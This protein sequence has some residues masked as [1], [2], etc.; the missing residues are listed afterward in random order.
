MPTGPYLQVTDITKEATIMQVREFK[1]SALFDYWGDC[2]E[3]LME[4]G[5]KR[6][7]FQDIY[8]QR[9]LFHIE[10][11]EMKDSVAAFGAY[12]V[13]ARAAGYKDSFYDYSFANDREALSAKGNWYLRI[14][15][16]KRD[17]V[18]GL[19]ILVNMSKL[20]LSKIPARPYVAPAILT[21]GSLRQFRS[22]LKLIRGYLGLYYGFP[23]WVNIFSGVKFREIAV[24]PLSQPGSWLNYARVAFAD[25][26]ELEKFQKKNDF[27]DPSNPGFRKRM[28]GQTYWAFL[29]IGENIALL[30]QSEGNDPFL[31]P[32]VEQIEMIGAKK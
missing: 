20:I 6:L 31:G 24:L 26:A 4:Y 12:S 16:L 7:I 29:R 27:F 10:L 8:L 22:E 30:L 23:S 18:Y 17:S 21:A 3:L 1:D 19:E 28:S 5:F 2:P 15:T 13:A 11:A 32:I 14:H 9:N 25:G